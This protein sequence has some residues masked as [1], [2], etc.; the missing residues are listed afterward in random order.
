MF[1]FGPGPTVQEGFLSNGFRLE[2][3]PVRV[4]NRP[5][6]ISAN[7]SDPRFLLC[8]QSDP[9]A[10]FSLFHSRYVHSLTHP[11]FINI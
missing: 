4:K 5:A 11:D 9:I 1:V 10:E 7:V 8:I 2:L 3:K 6:L